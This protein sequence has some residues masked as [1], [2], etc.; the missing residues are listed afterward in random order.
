M[1]TSIARSRRM[2]PWVWLAIAASI[3]LLLAANAH[4]VVAA[5]SSQPDCVAHSRAPGT[6]GSYRAAKSAC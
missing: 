6:D 2:R 5:V 4:L 3:C 1:S